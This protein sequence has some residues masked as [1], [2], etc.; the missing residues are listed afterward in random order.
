[1][2]ENEAPKVL[3]LLRITAP[4]ERAQDLQFNLIYRLPVKP[5]TLSEADVNDNVIYIDIPSGSP[6]VQ[7]IVDSINKL[8]SFD[9]AG[10]VF[11]T[12]DYDRETGE[13]RDVAKVPGI[14]YSPKVTATQEPVNESN[15]VSEPSETA[16]PVEPQAVV[17][18]PVEEP[19]E[20]PTEPEFDYAPEISESYE[21]TP[22]VDAAIE[23][24]D[25][26]HSIE[27]D[28][29]VIADKIRE[30][31]ER[32]ERAEDEDEK[33]ADQ[34]ASN[35]ELGLSYVSTLDIEKSD[36]QPYLL[37]EFAATKACEVVA[38]SVEN[39]ILSTNKRDLLRN[40]REVS[41]LSEDDDE[42]S[43]VGEGVYETDEVADIHLKFLRETSKLSR[44]FANDR[45]KV[46]D[47]DAEEVDKLLNDIQDKLYPEMNRD[48]DNADAVRVSVKESIEDMNS[49][50]VNY[51]LD[52]LDEMKQVME[53]AALDAAIEYAEEN[54]K[55]VLQACSDEMLLNTYE[56][57]A[58]FGKSTSQVISMLLKADCLI[59]MKDDIS[60]ELRAKYHALLAVAQYR[61]LSDKAMAEMVCELTEKRAAEIEESYATDNDDVDIDDVEDVDTQADEDETDDAEEA[62]EEPSDTEVAHEEPAT[63]IDD[64]DVITDGDVS[65]AEN[66]DDFGDLDLDTE[67]EADLGGDADVTNQLS[68]VSDDLDFGEVEDEID[69]PSV[70]G[71]PVNPLSKKEQK[72][73]ERE[74]KKAERAEKRKN[75]K[76]L[77]LA[78][79]IGIGVAT[80]LVAIAGAGFYFFNMSNGAGRSVESTTDPRGQYQVGD[81]YTVNVKGSDGKAAE[82]NL[83]VSKFVDSP[84]DSKDA[85]I[86]VDKDG[87]EYRISYD[88]MKDLKK[89]DAQNADTTASSQTSTDGGSQSAK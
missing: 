13:F 31:D 30:N 24:V 18:E 87:K 80:A 27:D 78:A 15:E 79:K 72:K 8:D 88:K 52:Y 20:E 63:P 51:R 64:L 33:F 37:P 73:L 69:E 55:S 85:I 70:P 61:A 10:F 39:P 84:D 4:P 22:T 1:M 44:E 28:V 43:I 14:D 38:D 53:K 62:D 58:T 82:K 66:L 7:H 12:V 56:N 21:V 25:D 89:A 17:G 40:V 41:M 60:D 57:A 26:A 35:N 32:I 59:D 29:E 67:P 36:I 77:P 83:T 46:Q 23:D 11:E 6:V 45:S 5:V 2:P 49:A 76:P 65:D 9:L 16:T 47:M 86:A 68:P 74:K 48:F 50:I 71:A 81:S 3:H 42:N 54:R 19:V 34:L 75:R